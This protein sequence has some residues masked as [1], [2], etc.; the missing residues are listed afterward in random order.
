MTPPRLS[1]V[2]P[3]YRRTDLL[4]HCLHSVQLCRPADSEVIVVDDGSAD[5]CVSCTAS[6]FSDVL[7]V[8][9]PKSRGFAAAANAGIARCQGDVIEMLNDDAE[10]T[11]GWAEPALARFADPRTV[12]VAPL[13]LIH[14]TA[15]Q[16]RPRI[17]S[18]GDEFDSGGFARKRHH[19][20]R[21]SEAHLT[22]GPVWGVSAAAGFYRRT[23]LQQA[24]GF[25]ESFGA[26][27]E[28]VD[29]SMRLRERG[30]EIVYEPRSVVWHRVSASYGRAPSR[31]VIEQQ[32]CNEER[33]FWR[34]TTPGI[35]LRQFPRH[36]A[37]LAGKTA[38][39]LAEGQ[40][41]PWLSGRL[42]AIRFAQ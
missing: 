4:S 17:D 31:K 3:S 8:R 35:R 21:L 19:G 39:R 28:D 16:A 7:V 25:A 34:Q 41:M 14:A 36:L 38:K 1:I 23:T 6:R 15:N 5:G 27:F 9:L 20:E 37:V 40:I 12:A 42:K 10:V 30:G 11:P 24:G 22:A 18:A 2:I 32:S 26:Y 13:V 29:L 33:L